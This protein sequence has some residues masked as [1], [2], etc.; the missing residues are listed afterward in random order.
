MGIERYAEKTVSSPEAFVPATEKIAAALEFC[1]EAHLNQFRKTGEPFYYHPVA[2]AQILID[3][4]ELGGDEDLIIAALLHDAVEDSGNGNQEKMLGLIGERFGAGVARLVDGVTKVDA[5]T[6]HETHRK[7]S[8]SSGVEPRVAILKIADR[9]HN[10]RTLEGMPPEKQIKKSR[11]TI[12]VYAPMAERLGWWSAK[13]ELEDRSF[14]YL[15][16]DEFKKIVDEVDNDPRLNPDFIANIRSGIE[17]LLQEK[18]IEGRVEARVNGY[19]A[20][21]RKK[22]KAITSGHTQAPRGLFDINDLVSFRVIV[23]SVDSCWL[24]HGAIN[25]DSRFKPLV[26]T[27]RFDDFITEPRLNGYSGLQATFNTD[28]GA[29]EIAYVTHEMEQ[30][31]RRGVA[32][33]IVS[34]EKDLSRYTLNAVFTPEGNIM[35]IPKGSTGLDY[36]YY[37]NP[38]TGANAEGLII[39]GEERPLSTVIPDSATV[40]IVVAEVERIAPPEDRLKWANPKTTQ[41][42]REQLN[43]LAAHELS[44]RGRIMAEGILAPRGILRLEDLGK[45]V[46]NLIERYRASI[47]DIYRRI[48]NGSIDGGQLNSWLDEQGITKEMLGLTTIKIG[49]KDRLG[50]LTEVSPWI[51]EECH[52]NIEFLESRSSGGEFEILFVVS[53]I[54]GRDENK[55]RKRFEADA[56]F[57]TWVVV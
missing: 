24:A 57:D 43:L 28:K 25:L 1:K 37:Y 44:V 45:K 3:E 55:L 5:A 30:F 22:E 15:Y 7:V 39:D 29:I 41:I 2:V 12:A 35:F 18:K 13:K 33:L 17:S 48:G 34:G 54:A 23:N 46:P 52:G 19:W 47:E 21:H 56:R 51:S 50:I 26:D 8:E 27:S 42:I 11:E 6:D 16:P 10:M 9:L 36:A 20:L 32:T 49:G 14:R 53:G 38:Q 4:L 31:N 40:G